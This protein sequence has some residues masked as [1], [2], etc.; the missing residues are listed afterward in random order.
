MDVGEVGGMR[1]KGT[2]AGTISGHD[3]RGEAYE[4][5]FMHSTRMGAP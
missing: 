1:W 3:K 2:I 4:L 5:R